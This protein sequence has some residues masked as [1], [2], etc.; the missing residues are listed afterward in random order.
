[1]LIK[2][3][4]YNI[5]NFFMYREFKIRKRTVRAVQ[6][7]NSVTSKDDIKTVRINITN[8]ILNNIGLKIVDG[9][10]NKIPKMVWLSSVQKG[11]ISNVNNHGYFVGL[12]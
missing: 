1:M 2:I 9:N 10:K 11:W 12:L 4:Y 5:V 8:T 6:N 7:L 3:I